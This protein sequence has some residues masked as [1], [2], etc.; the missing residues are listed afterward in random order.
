MLGDLVGPPP[1]RHLHLQTGQS[2]SE[3]TCCQTCT[4][5]TRSS[6]PSES[7]VKLLPGVLAILC[8][9]LELVS[10]PQSGRGYPRSPR[11]SL[12]TLNLGKTD[13]VI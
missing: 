4:T 13:G 2:G 5:L 1:P 9:E 11:Y 7:S 10:Q 8:P 6:P 12:I 3:W